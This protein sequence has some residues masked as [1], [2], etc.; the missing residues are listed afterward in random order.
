MT[1][2]GV[3]VERPE[4]KRLIGRPRHRWEDNIK[5][6]LQEVGWEGLDWIELA[7]DTDR[8]TSLVNAAMNLRV[9]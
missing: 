2:Y 1:A 4:G 5:M 8:W 7:Q 9:S 3:L 6:Y